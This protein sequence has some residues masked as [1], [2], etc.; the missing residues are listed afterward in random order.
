MKKPLKAIIFDLDGVITDTAEYH[1]LAWGALA[2]ELNIPFSKEFNEQLKGISRMESLEKILVHGG[3]STDYTEVQKRHL[4]N[5][6]N[7]HYKKLIDS[8]T[9]NDIL[10]GMKKFILEVKNTGIKLAIASASKN[11]VS[12]IT[13]LGLK[14]QFDVIVDAKTI[15]NGKPDPEVFLTAANLLKVEPK[16]CIG[17]E[18]AA[19]GVEAIKRAGMF[20][21]G[22]GSL[23]TLEKADRVYETTKDVT[24][25]EITKLYA[26]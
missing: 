14:D 8:L 4:A 11:A 22:I 13:S 18:D 26:N 20:A 17:I 16:H 12:V 1:F 5:M 10:P 21:I 23:N 7:E 6:K 24:L 9:P 25:K 19:A 3:K 2:K 15:K